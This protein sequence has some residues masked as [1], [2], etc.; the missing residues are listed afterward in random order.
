MASVGQPNIL[1]IFPDHDCHHHFCLVSFIMYFTKII[2]WRT[3]KFNIIYTQ[4]VNNNIGENAEIQS[5]F[6]C[7]LVSQAVLITT[8]LGTP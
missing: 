5:F 2:I 8:W 7:P 4:I 1:L 6:F 3:E